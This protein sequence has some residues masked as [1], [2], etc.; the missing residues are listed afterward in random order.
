MKASLAILLAGSL[1]TAAS[2]AARADETA[3]PATPEEHSAIDDFAAKK[4]VYVKR[5]NDQMATWQQKL[6]QYSKDAQAKS[7]EA[8]K[9]ADKELQ[10]AWAKTKEASHGLAAAT[11]TGWDKAKGAFENASRKMQEEWQQNTTH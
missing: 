11:A 2:L 4:D 5:M 9:D 6:D 1:L 7:Q 10:R 3:Q 8:G